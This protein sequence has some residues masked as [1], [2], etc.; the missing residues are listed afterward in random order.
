MDYLVYLIVQLFEGLLVVI[1]ERWS[2]AV[3][4]FFGRLAQ[5]LV[6][7]RRAAAV[8]NL[9]IAFGKEKSPA[10]IKATAR[11]SFEH[12]GMMV[13]E[14]FLLRRW[15]EKELADRITVS[16]RENFNLAMLP[17]GPGVCMLVA[18]FGAFEVAAATIKGGAFWLHLLA[19]GLKNPFLTRY[20]FSRGGPNSG[21]TVFPHKG[22]VKEL[23]GRVQA[24]QTLAFLGDQRGDVERGII[25]D[26][27]GTP[28]P[29]NEVFAKIAIESGA[30]V[31]PLS[32]W[33]V[34][35]GRFRA[36]FGKEIQIHPTGDRR[37][38]LITVSQAFHNQFE[39]WLRMCPEQGFWFQ[40]KWK[41]GPS[42]HRRK[43]EIASSLRSSQ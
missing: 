24:G 23:I 20:L 4:R 25:V 41:R 7:D 5:L 3:G 21:V 29:A 36:D 38:D 11:K 16:G 32:T 30:R 37:N 43:K 40:R 17:G 27:F 31:I 15:S 9:T 2:Y 34:A 42:R 28:A 33:R 1:P 19:T 22:A 35:E 14:F 13:I 8:E 26:Y 39:E 12:M 18:H 6:P 10:W